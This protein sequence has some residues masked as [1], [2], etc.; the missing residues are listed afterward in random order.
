M[1][2]ILARVN[3]FLSADSRRRQRRSRLRPGRRSRRCIRI[4]AMTAILLSLLIVGPGARA[5]S[6][7]GGLNSSGSSWDATPRYGSSTER[8]G[9]DP[10]SLPSWARSSPRSPSGPATARD[11][12]DNRPADGPGLPDGPES[13]P[14]SGTGLAVLAVAGASLAFRRL[15]NHPSATSE[16]GPASRSLD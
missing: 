14:I 13:V 15:R 3:L 11:R 8:T 9:R 7:T 12:G 1:V 10:V 6:P 16:D 4:V 2:S 5:Q